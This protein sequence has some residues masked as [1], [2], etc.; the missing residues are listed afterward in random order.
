[1]H[2][3]FK[4]NLKIYLVTKITRPHALH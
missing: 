4:P 3:F 2:S 1:L